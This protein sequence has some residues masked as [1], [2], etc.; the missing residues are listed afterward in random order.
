[1]P[2][3]SVVQNENVQQAVQE[4]IGLLGGIESFV[5]PNDEVIIKPN[6]VFALPSDTGF[7]TDPGVVQAIIELCRT[8]NSSDV[9]IA[10]ASSGSETTTTAF[11]NCGYSELARKFGVKLVDLNESPTTTVEIPGGKSLHDLR[12]PTIILESDVLINVPKLKLYRHSPGKRDW[13]SLSV[14][15]LMGAVPGKGVYSHSKPSEFPIKVSPAFWTPEGKLFHPHHQPWW[16]PRGEKKRIHA[17]LAEGI[18]DLNTVI[19]PTLN[20][21]DAMIISQDVDMRES[22]GESILKLNTIL[23][24]TDRLALDC[25]ATKIAGLDPFNI[26]Y[27]KCAAERGIGESDYKNIQ[28]VG[29]PFED[30]ASTW[31]KGLED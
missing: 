7:T 13:A 9:S 30:I 14:K 10:E 23:A 12:V 21:I 5:H 28:T 3:V 22:K 27:L 24:S 11:E 25:I 15:N 8:A 18:V 20:I 4:A 19:Q 31:E 6:L 1:M 2:I 29:T 17:N 16:S 26:S